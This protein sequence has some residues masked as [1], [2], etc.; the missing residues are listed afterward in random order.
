[1][2]RSRSH[3]IDEELDEDFREFLDANNVQGT[4]RQTADNVHFTVT[5]Y[6]IEPDNAKPIDVSDFPQY[7]AIANPRLFDRTQRRKV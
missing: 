7:L 5:F 4:V 2:P 6:W 3:E 1:M